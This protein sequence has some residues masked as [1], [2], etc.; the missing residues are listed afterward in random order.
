MIPM[1]SNVFKRTFSQGFRS[2][3]F[4]LVTSSSRAFDPEVFSNIVSISL[5]K[6]AVQGPWGLLYEEEKN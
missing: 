2:L 1:I 3:V 6:L 4:C 5:T